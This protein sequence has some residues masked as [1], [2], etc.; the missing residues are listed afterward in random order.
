MQTVLK[1]NII[2]IKQAELRE[3][4]EKWLGRSYNWSGLLFIIILKSIK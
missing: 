4:D 1:S 3:M 2:F